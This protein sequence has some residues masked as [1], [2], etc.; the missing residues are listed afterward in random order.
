MFRYADTNKLS[1]PGEGQVKIVTKVRKVTYI[2]KHPE[3]DKV[4]VTTEGFEIVEEL[5]VSPKGAKLAGP[6]RV[7]GSKVVDRTAR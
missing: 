4:R 1:Q 6:P 5:A 3:D 2:N 7:V